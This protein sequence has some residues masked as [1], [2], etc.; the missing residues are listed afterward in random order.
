MAGGRVNSG[1]QMGANMSDNRTFD[2]PGPDAI[3]RAALEDGTFQIQQCR[4]CGTHIFYPRA[5]C[6]ACGSTDLGWVTASGKG[7]VYSTTIVRQKPE[8]GGD[9]NICLVDLEEGPRLISRVVDTPPEEVRI[10]Q[11]VEAFIG[12]LDE[13]KV[14]LFRPAAAG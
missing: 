10:G 13:E 6:T 14:A 9:Y 1:R 2:S 12:E 8:R 4:D 3:Y 11:P 5:I 7:T